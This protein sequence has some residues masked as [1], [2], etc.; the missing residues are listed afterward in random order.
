MRTFFTA[1]THFQHRLVAGLRGFDSVAEHDDALVER[2]NS[3]VASGDTVWHLG[4]V[5]MFVNER[6]WELLAELHGTIHLIA[7]NHDPVWP[8]HRGAHKL[9]V[10]WLKRRFASVQAFA[11]LRWAGNQVLLSH[12]PYRGAGDHTETE[13]YSEYRLADGGWGKWLLHGHTHQAERQQGRMIHVGMD[14]WDLTPVPFETVMG[15]I[16][17]G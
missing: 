12:F 7:G 2:W 6:T 13:R 15:L 17:G 11:R 14:A 9:Q 8:G 4:D 10:D 5:A 1:D 3:V 16:D